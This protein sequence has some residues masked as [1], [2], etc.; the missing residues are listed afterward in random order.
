[1][2]SWKICLEQKRIFVWAH[3]VHKIL[4]VTDTISPERLESIR[5]CV[6]CVHTVR[7]HLLIYMMPTVHL[8]RLPP[9]AITCNRSFIRERGVAVKLS[10]LSSNGSLHGD[11][12]PPTSGGDGQQPAQPPPSPTYSM[13]SLLSWFQAMHSNAGELNLAYNPVELS[14]W[15]LFSIKLTCSTPRV[16]I[17]IHSIM[18]SL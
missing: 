15:R 14:W 8:G 12:S 9:Q 11:L 10:A 18:L 6:L 4:S 5:R 2:V 13:G 7:S 3:L 1:M 16:T 17:T